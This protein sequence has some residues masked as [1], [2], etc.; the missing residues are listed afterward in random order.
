MIRL[1]RLLSLLTCTTNTNTTDKNVSMG[2]RR[3]GDPYAYG[4][5]PISQTLFLRNA[6]DQ[7]SRCGVQY[8]VQLIFI[9]HRKIILVMCNRN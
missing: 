7:L 5:R 1:Y 8:Q 6:V 4:A 9:Q 2:V 3:T